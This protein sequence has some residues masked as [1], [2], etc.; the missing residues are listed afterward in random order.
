MSTDAR[1]ALMNASRQAAESL[2]TNKQRYEQYSI[3]TRF[4]AERMLGGVRYERLA[5]DPIR[6]LG[7]APNMY[8]RWNI[9]DAI[10]DALTSPASD[11]E[12]QPTL[13]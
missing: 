4:T 10:Q 9:V 7:P 6:G 1:K 12:N 2:V 11:Q 3:C 5:N 8:Y 13:F